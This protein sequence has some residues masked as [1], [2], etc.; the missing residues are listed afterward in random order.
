MIFNGG[1]SSPFSCVILS[2]G[3]SW[4]ASFLS[5]KALRSLCSAASLDRRSPRPFCPRER[6]GLRF[7]FS[8]IKPRGAD[9]EIQ[10]STEERQ[11]F[12]ATMDIYFGLELLFATTIP[13]VLSRKWLRI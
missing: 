6:F 7:R 5:K 11:R 12:Y 2:S 13:Q 10:M 3:I 1:S 4:T 9:R 8:L